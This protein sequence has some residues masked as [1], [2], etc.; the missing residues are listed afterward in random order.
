MKLRSVRVP[1]VNI[2][3][4]RLLTQYHKKKNGEAITYAQIDQRK[5]KMYV[6]S[7]STMIGSSYSSAKNEQRLRRWHTVVTEGA[8]LDRVCVMPRLCIVDSSGCHADY[9]NRECRL[10]R[11]ISVH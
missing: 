1:M 7:S 11:F 9:Y 8:A 3:Q 10:L 2:L 5:A 6:T 4:I